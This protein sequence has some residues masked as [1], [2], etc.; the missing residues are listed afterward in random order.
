MRSFNNEQWDIPGLR[1]ITQLQFGPAALDLGDAYAASAGS[2]WK[3]NGDGRPLE[4]V[5][6]VRP[7]HRM[8]IAFGS[9][10]LGI[11]DTKMVGTAGAR[12]NRDD[13]HPGRDI[14]KIYATRHFGTPGAVVSSEVVKTSV[15]VR[16]FDHL[17]KV[18]GVDLAALDR[19]P[20]TG[21]DARP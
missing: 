19:V 1:W 7:P 13:Q 4:R 14:D 9:H 18:A 15:T 20:A 12:I 10:G 17:P 16:G 2:W 11:S 5:F 8:R 3:N 21:Q 6:Q